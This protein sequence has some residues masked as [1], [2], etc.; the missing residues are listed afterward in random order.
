MATKREK[1]YA[2]LLLILGAATIP[3]ENDLT[4]FIFMLLFSVA[5]LWPGKKKDKKKKRNRLS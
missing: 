3:I 5:I 2:V 1:L 4:I